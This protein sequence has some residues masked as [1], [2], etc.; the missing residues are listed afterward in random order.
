MQKPSEDT[1][2]RSFIREQQEWRTR[3]L[4]RLAR[5]KTQLAKRWWILPGTMV[6][7]LGVQVILY[8]FEPQLYVSS[9]RMIVNLK[10]SIPEGSLYT[11][12][13][14]NFLGTQAALM[15]SPVVAERA[16]ARI[17][18]PGP[19]G[20]SA[21][22][23]LKALILPRTTIFVL[24]GTGPDSRYTQ[25]FVQACM[26]EYINLKKEMRAQTSDMTLAGI[27]EEVVRLEK[28]LRR[29][30]EECVSFS[31]T[32]SV[33]LLQEQGN[34]AAQFLS[35]LSQKLASLKSEWALQKVLSPDQNI[36]RSQ[37]PGLVGMSADPSGN[38][39]AAEPAGSPAVDYWRA[40]QQ[41]LLM[42]SERDDL[43]KRLRP[44]HP[45]MALLAEEIE[46]RERLLDIFRLQNAQRFESYKQ[47]LKLQMTSLES[48]V[49]ESEAQ[50][51]DLSRRDAEFKR[52]KANGQRIQ[53]LYDRLLA[54]MQTLDVN[55]QIS[56]ESVTIMEKACPSV[57]DASLFK[58]R[59]VVGGIIGLGVGLFLLVLIDRLDDRV[60][61]IGELAEL[62][63]EPVLAQIPFEK[64]AL[65]KGDSGLLNQADERYGFV[66]AYRSLRSSLLYLSGDEHRPRTLLVTSSV[67]NDG[68]SLTSANVA[69]MLAGAGSRVLLVDADLRKGSLHHR[70]GV[71]SAEPG[72]A[73]AI[74]E[75]RNLMCDSC[76]PGAKSVAGWNSFVKPTG[77]PNLFLLPRGRSTD[78]SSELFI[79]SGARDFLKAATAM[80]DFVL[81]DTA[82]V[83]AA[84]DVT[85][86]APHVDGVIFVIRSEHTSARVARAALDLLYARHVHVL[87]LVLNAFR[88]SLAGF[89]HYYKYKDYHASYSGA[90]AH[91]KSR[92]VEPARAQV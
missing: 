10:L 28:E 53:G 78:K 77:F 43:S 62:F 9:G 4:A 88:P 70:F 32:N 48:Q 26:E 55:K 74:G 33:V 27:T 8:R 17:S 81:L 25:G 87:G 90:P 12:E 73:E 51:L 36:E 5:F 76:G 11:E 92:A 41:L 64:S 56:P 63:R 50:L 82:P 57:A 52:L 34:T 44:K 37:E 35:G 49:R 71:S 79:G 24:Q 7:G 58:K 16:Q 30:D 23:A 61:S 3:F 45:R 38:F 13:L 22:V 46:R 66:E 86:L 47:S 39:I 54:T 31:S 60:S 69:I 59:L 2:E 91:N 65:R 75:V 6:A 83:M 18:E 20:Q 1:S 29:C 80:Y 40:R 21:P 14:N 72:L 85:S 67:P 84:D 19:E 89:Y 15:Q 68:K 42:K